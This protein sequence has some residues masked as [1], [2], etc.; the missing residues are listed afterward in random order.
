[1]EFP[2]CVLHFN[3]RL[4]KTIYQKNRYY[5]IQVKVVNHQTDQKTKIYKNKFVLF[6]MMNSLISTKNS[7]G[8]IRTTTLHQNDGNKQNY[9]SNVLCT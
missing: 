9:Q 2:Y 4:V 8:R 6:C 7:I 1:M 5:I 3:P